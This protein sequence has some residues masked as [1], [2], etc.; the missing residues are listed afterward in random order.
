MPDKGEVVEVSTWIEIPGQ[1][2]KV[3]KTGLAYKWCGRWEGARVSVVD[4]MRWDG[5]G[6]VGAR[7]AARYRQM[8]VKW[9]SN[10]SREAPAKPQPEVRVKQILASQLLLLPM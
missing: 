10:L 1:R 4:G 6:T 9:R 5:P 3:A 2:Q 7:V 8:S